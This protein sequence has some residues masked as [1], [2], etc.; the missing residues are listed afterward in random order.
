MAGLIMLV[1]V[2]VAGKA[3]KVPEDPGIAPRS[4]R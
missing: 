2:L 1:L 4:P 3:W